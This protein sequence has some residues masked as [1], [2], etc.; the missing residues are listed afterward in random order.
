MKLTAHWPNDLEMS[1]VVHNVQ[2]TMTNVQ[3]ILLIG[4]SVVEFIEVFRS[5]TNCRICRRI[6]MEHWPNANEKRCIHPNIWAVPPSPNRAYSLERIVSRNVMIM[7]VCFPQQTRKCL[8]A[9]SKYP[10]GQ[11]SDIL[12]LEAIQNSEGHFRAGLGQTEGAGRTGSSR[13]GEASARCPAPGRGTESFIRANR[14]ESGTL[15][16]P[17]LATDYISRASVSE[18]NKLLGFTA[19]A[20]PSSIW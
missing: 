3:S 2:F 17:G 12:P 7:V 15:G 14:R 5:M 8:L 1:K 20:S 16:T 4:Q 10:P 11:L 6:V 13:G 9:L 19:S 18:A